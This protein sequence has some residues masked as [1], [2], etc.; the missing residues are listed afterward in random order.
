MFG[1]P[2]QVLLQ[3][4]SRWKRYATMVTLPNAPP[5]VKK[6]PQDL[7]PPPGGMSRVVNTAADPKIRIL[8]E[9]FRRLRAEIATADSPGGGVGANWVIDFWVV[10]ET[11]FQKIAR[12][13]EGARPS[14]VLTGHSLGA[15]A[16][17]VMAA[18]MMWQR[19]GHLSEAMQIHWDSVRAPPLHDIS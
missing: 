10:I 9:S 6:T 15:G 16:A 11:E 17:S 14:L 2:E 18:M 4:H 19:A 12:E 5:Y 3:G 7:G 13:F 8:V 1:F